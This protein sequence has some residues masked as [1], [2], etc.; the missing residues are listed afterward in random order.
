MLQ[1]RLDRHKRGPTARGEILS[2]V[3]VAQRRFAPWTTLIITAAR[4]AYPQHESSRILRLPRPWLLRRKLRLVSCSGGCTNTVAIND[5]RPLGR[6]YGSVVRS[7]GSDVGP[8]KGLRRAPRLPS[9]SDVGPRKGLGRVPRLP[10]CGSITPLS[11][12]ED[13]AHTLVVPDFK[14]RIIR[15]STVLDNRIVVLRVIATDQ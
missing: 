7:R 15:M 6:I 9:C 13:L 14:R 8:R 2:L 1:G 3:F 10:S 11:R 4:W 5:G 12:R